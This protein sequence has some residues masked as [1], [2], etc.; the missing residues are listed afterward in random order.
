MR[1][2]QGVTLGAL[3]VR[4]DLARTRRHPTIEH[5]VVIY[6]NATILGGDTVV[7][8]SSVIG[9]NVWLTH[10]V[11]PHS[12]V[13]NVAVSER[14]GADAD[15]PLGIETLRRRRFARSSHEGARPSWRPSGTPRT[16][17]FSRLFDPRVEVWMKLERANPGG[18]I[19]DR[20]AL[21]MVEDAEAR[22]AASARAR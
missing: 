4:K 8:H 1:L 13:T 18:S 12:I 5:D 22:G 16:S 11:P 21:A 14:H 20:I 15:T 3:S 10:S 2:Y 9:G 17:G 6:A 19:K 7:G